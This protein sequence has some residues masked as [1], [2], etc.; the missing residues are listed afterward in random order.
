[1]PAGFVI[2]LE[3]MTSAIYD[4]VNEATNFPAEVPD[5]LISH[6]AGPVEGGFRVVDVWESPEHYDRFVQE[7][8][9]PAL[10]QVEGADA[11]SPPKVQEFP[12]HNQFHR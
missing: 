6:V 10:G 8:L 12:I 4:G 5:G 9:G 3:G 7:K 1:M 11:V 2:D